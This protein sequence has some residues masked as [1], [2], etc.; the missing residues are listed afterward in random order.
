MR[1]KIYF[2][3]SLRDVS[4]A[5]TTETKEKVNSL[6]FTIK[7]SLWKLCHSFVCFQCTEAGA[8]GVHG[9][10]VLRRVGLGHRPKNADAIVPDQNMVEGRVKDKGSNPKCAIPGIARVCQDVQNSEESTGKMIA[11]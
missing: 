11:S 1:K 6:I 10:L 8:R 7:S 9:V 2:A 5:S 3:V 4:T